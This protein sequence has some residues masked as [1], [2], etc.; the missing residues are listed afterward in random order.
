MPEQTQA[1]TD[2]QGSQ[3]P[4]AQGEMIPKAELEKLQ[5]QLADKSK[6]L[7]SLS[8]EHNTLKETLFTPEYIA[9]LEKDGQG[10][11]Q[12]QQQQQTQQVDNATLENMSRGEYTNYLLQRV[13]SEITPVIQKEFKTLR[14]NIDQVAASAER[15]A[16][17][18]KYPDAKDH[19]PEMVK[20][21][22]HFPG[23]SMEHAYKI[24]K[25]DAIDVKNAEE[26]E[27]AARAASEKPGGAPS[28]STET[29][30]YK[31]AKSAN[32]AAWQAIVGDNDKIE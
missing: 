26:Q 32:E 21:L 30:E 8:K 3:D 24:A 2:A 1:N 20:L 15:E 31:D 27:K 10:P 6:E 13:G 23:Y 18:K 11:V 29:A 9:S 7:D 14:T 25:Q 16:L 12:T 19:F 17:L 4:N 22:K 5:T 28:S